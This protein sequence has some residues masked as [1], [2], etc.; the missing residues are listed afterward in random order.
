MLDI[1]SQG[2]RFLAAISAVIISAGI[3]TSAMEVDPAAAGGLAVPSEVLTATT[4]PPSMHYARAG[5]TATQLGNGSILIAGGADPGFGAASAELYYPVYNTFTVT[6]DMLYAR[7]GQT[8]NRLRSGQVLIT[9]GNNMTAIAELYDPP[10][11]RFVNAGSMH[12]IRTGHTATL[13]PNGM[14]LLVGG[15]DNSGTISVASAEIYNPATH[16]FT[17]TGSMHTERKDH[18]ATL[19][20]NGKVLIAGGFGPKGLVATA[21]LYDPATGHFTPTGTMHV[22]RR[23]HTATLLPSGRVLMVGGETDGVAFASASVELFNPSNG[24]STLTRSLAA[25]RRQHTATLQPDGTVLIAGGFNHIAYN[26]GRLCV[27]YGVPCV[28]LVPAPTIETYHA[29]TGLFSAPTPGPAVAMQ[30]A[31]ALPGPETWFA[32]G[33]VVVW[34]CVAPCTYVLHYYANERTNATSVIQ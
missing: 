7:T 27:F 2:T 6:G 15:A 14:V 24:T 19:L 4:A 20:T 11:G 5:H 8:A 9:G 12:S 32:G 29:S 34:K 25:A 23:Y 17:L 22:A 10:T 1:R 28:V 30:T 21:E 31:S 18:T 3:T 26:N 16:A 33:W 13:L